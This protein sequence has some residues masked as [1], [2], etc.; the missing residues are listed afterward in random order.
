[1]EQQLAK[2]DA[3]PTAPQLRQREPDPLGADND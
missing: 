3:L 1:V 2:L